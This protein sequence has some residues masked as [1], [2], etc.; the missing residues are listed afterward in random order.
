M[1]DDPADIA[2][3]HR[4]RR[5]RPLPRRGAARAAD[6]VRPRSAGHR[7]EGVQRP[8]RAPPPARPP[9]CR[10]DRRDGSG[11]ARR[12]LPRAT[13]PAPLP[14]L[15]G[16]QGPGAVRGDRDRLWQR[17]RPGL[18]RGARRRRPRAA[19]AG[20]ARHRRDEGQVAHRGARQPVRRPAA[21]LRRG[22]ADV[23]DP[24]RR[25]LGRGPRHLPGRQARPQGRDARR[26]RT[27][28]RPASGRPGPRALRHGQR[29]DITTTGRR[30]GL[31]R[32]IE[33]VFHNFDGR[34]YITGTPSAE[35]TRAWLLNLEAD[36]HFTFHLKGSRQRR[37]RRRPRGSSPTRRNGA[38]SSPRSSRSGPARTSRR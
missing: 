19:P 11:R 10:A 22:R 25:R 17:R 26:P 15:D 8:A 12:G 16:G 38:P 18:A 1:A 35:R 21:R 29:I 6:R 9:R 7:P 36:P 37:P 33:I 3:V 14:G 4:R 34:L 20:P 30:T 2:A 23:A 31:P 28:D 5:S 24:R 27:A 32:R 13:R